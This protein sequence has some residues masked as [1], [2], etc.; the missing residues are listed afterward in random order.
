MYLE[1][2]VSHTFLFDTG[3]SDYIVV[4]YEDNNYEFYSDFCLRDSSLNYFTDRIY[5]DKQCA[6]MRT[7]KINQMTMKYLSASI[8][9]S[10][11]ITSNAI[12]APFL[13]RFKYMLY[14]SKNQRICFFY[15]Q[16]G[17]GYKA[18]EE[19]DLTD[20]IIKSFLEKGSTELLSS[21]KK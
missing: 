10:N 21:R 13:R 5:F 1:D 4:D 14:D 8:N 2:S 11:I 9:S 19:K 16:K 7:L 17:N 3:W 18:N 15:S 6:L 20:K 12:A